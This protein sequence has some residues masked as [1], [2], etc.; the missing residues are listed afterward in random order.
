MQQS[1]TYQLFSYFRSSCSYRVRIALNWKG[2]SY[3]Y[4]PVHLV[5]GGG[6]QLLPEYLLRNPQGEVPALYNGQITISQSMAILE[7]LEE[8]HP[9]PPLLGTTAEERARIRQIS[10][11]INSGIQP[12]QNLKVLQYIK[13]EFSLSD[14]QKNEWAKYWI[15]RG[16][17]SV[18]QMLQLT[19]GQYCV[20]DKVTLADCF[21]VPQVYNAR[22]FAVN[23]A[24]FPLISQIDGNCSQLPPFRSAHPDCQPDSPQ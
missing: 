3:K 16:L 19:H 22:R 15:E 17:N 21:L 9:C 23:L 5:K 11:M 4:S 18:E 7:Y 2:L 6:E 10:E 20:G 14:D 1:T 12:L 13:S 24:D 8:S